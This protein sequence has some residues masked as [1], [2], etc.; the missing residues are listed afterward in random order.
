MLGRN[1]LA[2]YLFSELL[3]VVLELVH[4][5]GKG[6]YTWVGPGADDFGSGA[7]TRGRLRL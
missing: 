1:P 5:D 7:V 2:I 6:L 3:V 4:V